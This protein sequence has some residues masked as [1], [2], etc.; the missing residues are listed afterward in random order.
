MQNIR[1]VMVLGQVSTS[2]L[3]I[4]RRHRWV[5]PS[6]CVR[7]HLPRNFAALVV[8][9]WETD[10]PALCTSKAKGNI[11]AQRHVVEASTRVTDSYAPRRVTKIYR[12]VT[13]GVKASVP[14][15]SGS[16]W[17]SRRHPYPPKR[18]AQWFQVF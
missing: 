5:M 13:V 4:I 6:L 7:T 10:V 2:F 3:H 16:H 18:P 12:R 17:S 15:K 8:L 11:S 1:L 9:Q 14:L